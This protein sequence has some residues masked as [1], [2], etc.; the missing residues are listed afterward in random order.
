M[1]KKLLEIIDIMIETRAEHLRKNPH[2][3]NWY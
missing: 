1:I 2:L 3:A